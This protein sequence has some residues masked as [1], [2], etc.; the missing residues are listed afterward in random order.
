MTLSAGIKM[1]FN[2]FLKTVAA[3]L[4]LMLLLSVPAFANTA[5][6]TITVDKNGDY[7]ETQNAYNP[8]TTI[9]K[10]DDEVLNKPSDM[11]IKDGKLYIADTG[12]KR[13]V[14]SSLEGKLIS[15]IGNGTLE[16]P[17]G[18]FIAENGDILV[19]DMS[20]KAVFAFAADG[21]LL[22]K[23]EKPKSVLYGE[24]ETFIPLKVAADGNDTL[25]IS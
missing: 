5:Y 22:K 25:Y 3:S 1:R 7:I 13:V 17:K 18:I 23:Y 9:E 21:S 14:V 19:A 24:E 2:K 10:I 20:A 15:V 6:K 16:E 12:N 4:A 11:A 8:V